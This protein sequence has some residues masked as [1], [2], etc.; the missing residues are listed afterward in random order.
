M[1]SLIK[2]NIPFTRKLPVEKSAPIMCFSI[3]MW[4]W[5]NLIFHSRVRVQL[6]SAKK[7]SWTFTQ[8]PFRFP[9][10]AIYGLTNDQ[11]KSRLTNIFKQNDIFL[12]YCTCFGITY[13]IKYKIRFKSSG[14]RITKESILLDNKL[15]RKMFEKLFTVN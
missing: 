8:Y 4:V 14:R 13:A 12:V 3:I 5:S 9:D 1:F 2:I 15:C 6:I 11:V 7:S 10:I